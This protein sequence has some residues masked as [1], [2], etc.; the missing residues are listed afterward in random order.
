M[1]NVGFE[2]LN[3]DIDHLEVMSIK[4]TVPLSLTDPPY[5]TRSE[6]HFPN[7]S[8]ESMTVE[9]MRQCVNIFAEELRLGGH[10]FIFCS[11]LQFHH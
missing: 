3:D 4:D 2:E 5:S 11:M 7:S 8:H 10:G 6:R 9:Q 1:G